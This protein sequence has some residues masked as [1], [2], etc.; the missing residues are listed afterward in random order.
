MSSVPGA[1]AAPYS[2][3]SMTFL[4]RGSTGRTPMSEMFIVEPPIDH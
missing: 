1:A 3:Q 2:E 4:L